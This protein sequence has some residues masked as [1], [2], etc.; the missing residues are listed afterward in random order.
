MKAALVSAHAES[1][2][3]AGAAA[4]RSSDGSGDP[5]WAL[6]EAAL[7]IREREGIHKQGARMWEPL[8]CLLG[9]S[10]KPR[11]R[12]P[13]APAGAACYLLLRCNWRP[14]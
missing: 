9:I 4:Q 11:R 1:R 13:R 8:G 14:P 2:D 12:K 10:L 7:A 5:D 6:G 3:V